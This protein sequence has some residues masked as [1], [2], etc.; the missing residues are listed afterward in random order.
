MEIWLGL[1]T[2]WLGEGKTVSVEAVTL[3]Y[4]RVLGYFVILPWPVVPF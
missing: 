2:M 1:F 4:I 3:I